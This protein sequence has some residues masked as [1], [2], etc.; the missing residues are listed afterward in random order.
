MKPELRITFKK[1]RLTEALLDGRVQSSRISLRFVPVEP[2]SQAFR[3]AI[4]DHEFDVSE[5]ALATLAMA[6]DLGLAWKGLPVM[7]AGGFHHGALRVKFDSPILTPV[8]L[9]GCTIGSRAYSQTTGVWFR[10]ILETEYG[11]SPNRMRWVTIEDAHVPNFRDPEFVARA[12][13]G[14]KLEDMFAAGEVDAVI[15]DSATK[16]VETRSVIPDP[17]AVAVAWAAR[18][19]VRPVNHVLA[20]RPGLADELP[21]LGAE[22]I[23]MIGLSGVGACDP[24]SINAGLAFT[25]SQGLTRR[26]YSYEDL[27]PRLAF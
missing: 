4:R 3:R 11:I 16:F 5:M 20:L 15:G 18:T 25:S 10:G 13:V 21:W 1:T 19:G 22:L 7:L 6:N 17:E 24:V 12:P 8:D 9:A 26:R 23:R 2:I 14:S 27:F